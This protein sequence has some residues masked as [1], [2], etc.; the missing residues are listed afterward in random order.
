[1]NEMNNELICL[2]VPNFQGNEKKYVDQAVD[3]EWVST[4]GPFIASFE[5]NMAETMG[6]PQACA[7]QS[8]TA[9]LHLCLRHF[10]IGEN[11]IVLVPTLTFIAP[12]NAVVYQNATPVFFDC[13]ENLCIDAKQV[14]EYLREQC[15][16]RDG[17]TVEKDSG[18]TVKAILPVHVFGDHCDMDSLMALAAEFGLIVIEDATEAVGGHFAKGAYAGK[19]IGTVGHAGVLSF[20]G[21]KIITTGGGGMVLSNDAPTVEHIR[22]LSQQAKDDTLY[23]VHGEVGYNY[24]MTN[25]QAALGLAQLEELPGFVDIKKKNYL[26]YCELLRDCRYASMLPFGS[27]NSSNHWFYSFALHEADP[28][29]RDRLIRYMN[30]QQIQVRP[31]WKLNHTQNM[32]RRYKAMPCPR[33]ADYYDRVINI[34]CSTNLTEAQQDRVCDALLKFC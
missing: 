27:G 23:F 15:V 28:G 12:I 9:G 2:S 26:R 14:E 24:R 4:A 34:P 8:G 16:V 31:I 29:K 11:D 5:K 32:F 7:C 13:D 1:M 30:D 18:K 19:A 21:N 22:Y 33:A 6:V 3:E 25:L 17:H 10:G 20:N